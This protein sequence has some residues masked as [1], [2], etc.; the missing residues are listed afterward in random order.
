[1]PTPHHPRTTPA[2][3][4]HHP[5]TTQRTGVEEL[6]SHPPWVLGAPLHPHQ[7]AALNWMRTAWANQTN[8]LLADDTG[9]GKTATVLSFLQ[10]LRV[11]FVQ[12]GPVLV[13]VPAHTLEFW[14]G[15]IS[16]WL[17]GEV[18]AA[19]AAG[20]V[21][22][23]NQVYDHELWLLPGSMDLKRLNAKRQDRLQQAKVRQGGWGSRERVCV[24]S[25]CVGWCV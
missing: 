25:V 15:E 7:L 12:R 2:P 20:T 3:P 22:A 1:M 18:S 9:Q 16:F 14:E 8:V 4:P 11:E 17:G 23:R 24:C 13:V 21:T 6:T 19:T 10:S 5:H